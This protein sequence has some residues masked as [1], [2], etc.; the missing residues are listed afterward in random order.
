MYIH[1]FKCFFYFYASNKLLR[2]IVSFL[3][4]RK[5]INDLRAL[6]STRRALTE[7]QNTFIGFCCFVSNLKIYIQNL[8]SNFFFFKY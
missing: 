8:L 1:L 6:K 7:T 5:V 4:P 3:T 2:I